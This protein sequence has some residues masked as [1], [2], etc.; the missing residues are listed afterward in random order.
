MDIAKTKNK[1]KSVDRDLNKG[2]INLIFL[3]MCGHIFRIKYITT[4][5][6]LM[7]HTY[8]TKQMSLPESKEQVLSG[9]VTLL[10]IIT[11]KIMCC[12]TEGKNSLGNLFILVGCHIRAALIG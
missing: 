9:L 7:Y 5:S 8:N 6:I 4:I 11:R 2:I 12:Q 10:S 1:H 3:C